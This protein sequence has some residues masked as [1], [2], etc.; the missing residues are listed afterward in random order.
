MAQRFKSNNVGSVVPLRPEDLLIA[1]GTPAALDAGGFHY[2]RIR[3]ERSGYAERA[4]YIYL[5]AGLQFGHAETHV[6]EASIYSLEEDLAVIATQSHRFRRPDDPN[7]RVHSL[8]FWSGGRQVEIVAPVRPNALDD[9]DASSL[10]ARFWQTIH[11]LFSK[12]QNAA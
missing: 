8:D 1:G 11:A 12:S 2:T 3:V 4:D 6:S 9:K 5:P 10:L 7:D